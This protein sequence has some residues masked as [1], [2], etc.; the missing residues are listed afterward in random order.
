MGKSTQIY[1][2]YFYIKVSSVTFTNINIQVYAVPSLSQHVKLPTEIR[3]NFW[4]PCGNHGQMGKAFGLQVPVKWIF[5]SC[6]L[7]GRIFIMFCNEVW[8]D[9][10]FVFNREVLL[11]F[12]GNRL[13]K[14]SY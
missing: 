8:R 11:V 1:F 13:L 5:V 2:Y 9:H 7:C 4:G 14:L 12:S 3:V 10:Y 6:Y